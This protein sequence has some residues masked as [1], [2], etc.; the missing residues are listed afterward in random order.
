[1]ID[2]CIPT[3]Y[4]AQQTMDTLDPIIARRN[5]VAAALTE[6]ESLRSALNDA[7]A[8]ALLD[9]ATAQIDAEAARTLDQSDIQILPHLVEY[10]DRVRRVVRYVNRCVNAANA[11]DLEPGDDVYYTESLE[12]S[13]ANLSG[14]PIDSNRLAIIRRL[15]V[16][17]NSQGDTVFNEI[18]ALLTA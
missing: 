4:G 7:Q 2:C 18:M 11:F 5:L 10:T 3:Q 15:I 14:K 12:Q 16:N 6:N 8:Q 17:S 13:Y 1:M 9:W